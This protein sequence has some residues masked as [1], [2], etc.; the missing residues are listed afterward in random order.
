MALPTITDPLYGQQW[1]LGRLGGDMRVIWGDYTGAGIHSAVYDDGLQSNH[2]D[3]LGT[4]DASRE[5]TVGGVRSN[6]NAGA[7]VHGTAVAGIIGAGLDGVG[8]VGISYGVGLTGVDVFSGA[9]SGSGQLSAIRQMANF[10]TVNNSWNWTAK[11]ADPISVV[12]SFGQQFNANLGYAVASGRGGYGTIIVDS[13]GNDWYTDRRD[14]NTSEFAATRYTIT[15]GAVTDTGDVAYYANRGANLLISAPSSGG[16]QGMTTTDRTGIG[17]YDAGDH[18][19]T[20]GGTSGAAPVVTGVSNLMLDA[21]ANLG[22]RD[23]QNIMAITALHTTGNLAGGTSGEMAF[24]WTINGAVNV[25]G[26]GYH[27][28]NDVGYGS[29]NAFEAVRFAEVWS[30][31]APAQTSTNEQKLT[32]SATLNQALADNQTRSFTFNVAGNLSVEHADLTLTLSHANVNQLRVELVSPDGT[33]SVVLTP[34]TGTAIA[35]NNWSW[36]FGSEAFHGELAA[37]TWTVRVTDTAAGATGMLSSARLDLF[38]EAASY[39]QVYHY[40]QEFAKMLALD[41]SRGTL[42]DI[43]GGTD[44]INAAGLTGA[45]NLDLHAGSQTTHNGQAMFR[46]TPATMIE[47]AV[48][49]DGNDLLVGNDL[50]NKLMGMRGDDTLEGYDGADTLD[51]GLG[52]DTA[53]YLHSNYGVDLDLNRAIQ[54]G[55][56][57][58]GDRLVSI[59][60]LTGSNHADTLRG[61][62]GANVLSGGAGNDLLEG[63]AGAD[64]LDGGTGTDTASYASSNAGVDIDMARATQLGGHAAGDRLVSIERLIGSESADRIN[65]GSALSE[66]LAGGGNDTII[67][68]MA[69]QRIDGGTGTDLVDFSL[70][71]AGVS[72]NLATGAAAGGFAQGDLLAAIENVT[73]STWNDTLFGNALNNELRGGVGNDYLDGGDGDDRLFGGDGVDRLMGGAGNDYLEGGAGNDML[74]G[75]AGADLFAFTARGWGTDIVTDFARGTDRLD[76][77]G[78]GLSLADVSLSW[79]GTQE[80]VRFRGIADTIVLQ[81]QASAVTASDFLFA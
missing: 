57:A 55:G 67:A 78:T 63:Y 37:G 22:W 61:D 19:N 34:G 31:F 23:V 42:T 54:I 30:N 72:V 79:N 1:Y 70:S 9:A 32:A 17:G 68:S 10:D 13:A 28:S 48:T 7:G 4:Y 51:G 77:R 53:T 66:I 52:S 65:G 18:T 46:I 27:F 15:V 39:D 69:G 11:Y 16:Y 33:N 44:W 3:L 74:A 25:N 58:Q 80:T 5:I 71:T 47:N 35:Q 41:P 81:A 12:G 64:V 26:G 62:A 8:G 38:G 49:G 36:S 76:M 43:E 73:G 29:I 21:N 40:T 45:I 24:G 20:F 50:V 59:E 56:H 2:P 14:A 60:N 6:P 75:G